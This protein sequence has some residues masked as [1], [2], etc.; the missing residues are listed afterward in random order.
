VVRRTRRGPTLCVSRPLGPL[1]VVFLDVTY[2]CACGGAG[3]CQA[4]CRQGLAPLGESPL[5]A[6]SRAGVGDHRPPSIPPIPRSRTALGVHR[7]VWGGA[8]G[9]SLRSTP[10]SSLQPFQGTLGGTVDS[11]PRNGLGPYS[12]QRLND[13]V[14]LGG[15]AIG[16]STRRLSRHHRRPVLAAHPPAGCSLRSTHG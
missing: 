5:S 8:P 6:G 11:S 2:G 14:T 12:T 9:V 10:R 13:L 3:R 7:S 16:E 1:E 4:G 15:C